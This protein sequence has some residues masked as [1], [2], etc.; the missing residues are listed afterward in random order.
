[1]IG[2]CCAR[3]ASLP[4]KHQAIGSKY[5]I[6]LVSSKGELVFKILFAKLK[7][8]PASRLWQ[9]VLLSY[10][11]AIEHDTAYQYLSF[12]YRFMMFV[13]SLTRNAKQSAKRLDFIVKVAL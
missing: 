6:E 11:L 7:Q 1:V 12:I 3:L 9:V 10:I 5:V 4:A 13:V 8:L 2:V